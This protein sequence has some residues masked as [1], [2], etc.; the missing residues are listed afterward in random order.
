MKPARDRTHL[1][2]HLAFNRFALLGQQFAGVGS[3][4]SGGVIRNYNHWN[5][6]EIFFDRL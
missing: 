2:A 5:R 3:V 6:H 4:G 1:V